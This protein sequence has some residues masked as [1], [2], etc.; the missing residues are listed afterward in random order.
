MIIIVGV[1]I[2]RT[3]VRA[4]VCVHT[5]TSH[6]NDGKQIGADRRDWKTAATTTASTTTTKTTTTMTT[7]MFTRRFYAR[8]TAPVVACCVQV[9]VHGLIW[10]YRLVVNT[11]TGI[12]IYTCIHMV[13]LCLYTKNIFGQVCCGARGNHPTLIYKL[14]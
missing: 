2:V 14:L 12:I 11:H 6:G 13:I 3:H 8:N 1:F 4:C 10:Y 7:T 5:A 9:C